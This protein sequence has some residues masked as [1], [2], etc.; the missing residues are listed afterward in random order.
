MRHRF[1]SAP[2]A[3]IFNAVASAGYEAEVV[4][5]FLKAAVGGSNAA[6]EAMLAEHGPGLLDTRDDA[7]RTALICA[8]ETGHYGA[9]AVLI[10]NGAEIDARTHEGKTA[11]MSAAYKGFKAVAETL[12]DRGAGMNLADIHGR[13]VLQHAAS[14]RNNT[15][16]KHPMSRTKKETLSLLLDRGARTD[17]TDNDGHTPETWARRYGYDGAG[18]FIAAEA[19]RRKEEH[20]TRLFTEGLPDDITVIR[21]RLR[22]RHGYW[23]G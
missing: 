8:A 20:D 6:I 7:G 16:H 23:R 2:K 5:K 1:Q 10:K 11:L 15:D 17:L 21:L 9:I 14:H 19:A 13:S 18:D 12:L 22:H 3:H 4:G